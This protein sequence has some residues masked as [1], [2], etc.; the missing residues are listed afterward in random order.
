MLT[1]LL[2]RSHHVD[3]VSGMTTPVWINTIRV[4]LTWREQATKTP[5]FALY[6]N[7]LCVGTV[8]ESYLV[9]ADK[10]WASWLNDEGSGRTISR[11]PTEAAAKTALVEAVVRELMQT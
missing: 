2:A 4:A 3:G 10:S 11:H 7:G 5:D 9:G 8:F 6:I 1:L